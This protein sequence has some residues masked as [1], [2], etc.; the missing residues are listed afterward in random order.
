MRIEEMIIRGEVSFRR[1]GDEVGE[2]DGRELGDSA[3]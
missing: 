3:S 2:D 1:D